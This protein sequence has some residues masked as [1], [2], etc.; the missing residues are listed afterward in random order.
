LI[1]SKDVEL[2]EDLINLLRAVR[3]PSADELNN[4]RSEYNADREENDSM[5]EWRDYYEYSFD[6]NRIF[7]YTP[8][9]GESTSSA[10]SSE[11]ETPA[12]TGE[13]F[14]TEDNS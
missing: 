13:E 2:K 10:T 1:G 4:L 7:K 12:E 11:V 6:L 5:P 14:S 3:E 8:P 9:V